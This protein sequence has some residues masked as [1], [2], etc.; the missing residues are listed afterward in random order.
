MLYQ[1]FRDE[2]D[3]PCFPTLD[4]DTGLIQPALFSWPLMAEFQAMVLSD[5]NW[6][7]SCP[8]HQVGCNSVSNAGGAARAL[9]SAESVHIVLVASVL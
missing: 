9:L 8:A 3:S 4:D 1:Y 7:L 2:S 5:Y 6:L